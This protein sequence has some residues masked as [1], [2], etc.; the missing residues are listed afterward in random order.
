MLAPRGIPRPP[1]PSTTYLPRQ[2]IG[3]RAIGMCGVCREPDAS[4]QEPCGGHARTLQNYARP[5][6]SFNAPRYRNGIH[7]DTVPLR[8]R[9]SKKPTPIR[10]SASS[11]VSEALFCQMA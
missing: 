6:T 10:R 2:F 5:C 8:S 7:S 4:A 9:F 3:I 11:A 1:D